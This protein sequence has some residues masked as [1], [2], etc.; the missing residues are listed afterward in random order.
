MG[1]LARLFEG[2]NCC[3]A[4]AVKE[5]DEGDAA[6]QPAEEDADEVRSRV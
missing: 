6:A 5:D 1:R 3:R 4:P 2:L